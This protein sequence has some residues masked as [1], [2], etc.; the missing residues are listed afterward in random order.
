MT[1]PSVMFIEMA[2]DRLKTVPDWLALSQRKELQTF[3]DYRAK[4]IGATG[5]SDDFIRG[6][7]LG[8]STARVIISMSVA[9][10][11]GGTPDQI[12]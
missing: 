6:Y 4:A 11:V 7:E 5:V 9:A 12:L 10:V 2:A 1:S 8:L 3:G